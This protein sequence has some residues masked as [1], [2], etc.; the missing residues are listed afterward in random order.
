MDGDLKQFEEEME[1]LVPAS[2]PDGLISRMEAAMVGWQDEAPAQEEK[3]V[4]FPQVQSEKR[5]RQGSVSGFW[6]TA[7]VVALLGAVVALVLPQSGTPAG[8]PEAQASPSVAEH[9]FAAVSFAPT[10]AGR[11]IVHASGGGVVFTKDDRP[12]RVVRIEYVDR[13]EYRN[14][15]GEELYVETPAVKLILIPVETD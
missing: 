2:M 5:Q 10:N 9:N 4:P 14:A 8:A 13:I 6:A 11:N 7:A 15:M 12:H 3:V 1:R